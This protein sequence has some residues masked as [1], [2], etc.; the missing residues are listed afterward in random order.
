MNRQETMQVLALLRE[1]YPQGAE[2]TEMT[3]NVWADL[4]S[5]TPYEVTWEAAKE[6]CRTWE[7]YTMPPPAEL[8]KVIRNADSR[9]RTLMEKWR[10]VEKLIKRGTRLTQE[11]FDKQDEDIKA[12]FG[13]VSAIRD[14][15]LLNMDEIPNERA[16]FLKHMPAVQERIE[17]QAR[18]PQSVREMLEQVPVKKIAG[19]HETDSEEELDRLW[20]VSRQ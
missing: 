6:V 12:Y 14:L 2:I 8:F 18:L 1:A 13:G 10:K 4:F 9:T 7:G 3:V 16:R 5:D 15:A 17:A 19:A 20:V 11:E